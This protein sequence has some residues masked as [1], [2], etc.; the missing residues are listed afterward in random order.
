MHLV[1]KKDDINDVFRFRKLFG[2]DEFS[3]KVKEDSVYLAKDKDGLFI[4][5]SL[6]DPNILFT[7]KDQKAR[8]TLHSI[9]K[10]NK[11]FTKSNE[12]EDVFKD[13]YLD[14]FEQLPIETFKR[15]RFIGRPKGIGFSIS[16]DEIKLLKELGIKINV[17]TAKKSKATFIKAKDYNKIHKQLTG[18]YNELS[19]KEQGIKVDTEKTL[20][21]QEKTWANDY[22][23]DEKSIFVNKKGLR[24]FTELTGTFEESEQLQRYFVLANIAKS[25][26][27]LSREQ[28]TTNVSRDVINLSDDKN[29]NSVMIPREQDVNKYVSYLKQRG[30]IQKVD[31]ATG[32]VIKNDD[33]G[34]FVL[35]K[36]GKNTLEDSRYMKQNKVTTKELANIHTLSPERRKAVQTSLSNLNDRYGDKMEQLENFFTKNKL[37]NV[38]D[39]TQIRSTYNDF[40][41]TFDKPWRKQMDKDHV[42]LVTN[43]LV[44]EIGRRKTANVGRWTR[45]GL[46]M[47]R[48]A[49]EA[50][51]NLVKIRQ[52]AKDGKKQRIQ[53]YEYRGKGQYRKRVPVYKTFNLSVE[54][55]DKKIKLADKNIEKGVISYR[56]GRQSDLSLK[57]RADPSHVNYLQTTVLDDMGS[58][59]KLGKELQSV[60]NEIEEVEKIIVAADKAAG[61]YDNASLDKGKGFI[62]FSENGKPIATPNDIKDQMAHTMGKI[63]SDEMVVDEQLFDIVKRVTVGE[64]L[65]I[66][67]EIIRKPSNFDKYMT[68]RTK[69]GNITEATTKYENRL[70]N[71]YKELTTLNP[72]I[73]EADKQEKLLDMLSATKGRTDRKIREN[74]L[75]QKELVKQGIDPNDKPPFTYLFNVKNKV[76]QIDEALK[77][78]GYSK[79]GKMTFVE[80]GNKAKVRE[81]LVD[82]EKFTEMGTKEIQFSSWTQMIKSK[83]DIFRYK[84][85]DDKGAAIDFDQLVK[86]VNNEDI[87]ARRHGNTL[88][89]NMEDN[90]RL[91][92]Q[93]RIDLDATR[94]FI[95]N[96]EVGSTNPFVVSDGLDKFG[97]K[98]RG[99]GIRDDAGEAEEFAGIMD[100]TKNIKKPEALALNYLEILKSKEELKTISDIVDHRTVT[101][102]DAKAV[103]DENI[104]AT[105]NLLDGIQK[106]YGDISIRAIDDDSILASRQAFSKTQKEINALN[107]ERDV[108]EKATGINTIKS[109]LET[110]QKELDGLTKQK[111][112]FINSGRPQSDIDRTTVLLKQKTRDVGKLENDL[113][114]AKNKDMGGGRTYQDVL[115]DITRKDEKR[116]YHL[117]QLSYSESSAG[118][119]DEF[120]YLHTLKQAFVD[121]PEVDKVMK[122][123]EIIQTNTKERSKA[124]LAFKNA[125]DD[126]EAEY[127]VTSSGLSKFLGSYLTFVEKT[128][129]MK[130]IAPQK[131]KSMISDDS[132][133]AGVDVDIVLK[134]LDG[135]SPYIP[136]ASQAKYNKVMAALDADYSNNYH[137]KR[138]NELKDKLVVDKIKGGKET[139]TDKYGVT[140]T[141]TPAYQ[142]WKVDRAFRDH[143]KSTK[144]DR[145]MIGN[146]DNLITELETKFNKYEPTGSQTNEY[147]VKKQ[148]EIRGQ[149]QFLKNQKTKYEQTVTEVEQAS[150]RYGEADHLL[151][152]ELKIINNDLQMSAQMKKFAKSE[153]N[154]FETARET[155][156]SQL[157][158]HLV[159]RSNL[160]MKRMDIRRNIEGK[161]KKIADTNSRIDALSEMDEKGLKGMF[162]TMTTHRITINPKSAKNPEKLATDISEILSASQRTGLK[163]KTDTLTAAMKGHT[164]QRLDD[165]EFSASI[166]KFVEDFEIER[167]AKINRRENPD[168]I[169]S[170]DL[171]EAQLKA[172]AKEGKG[173]VTQLKAGEQ[174]TQPSGI[175]A[176]TILRS[177]DLTLRQRL[178][179]LGLPIRR[180]VAKTKDKD[181]KLGPRGTERSSFEEIVTKM[182]DGKVSFDDIKKFDV[183]DQEARALQNVINDAFRDSTVHSKTTGMSKI[184]KLVRLASGKSKVAEVTKNK[185]YEQ[186]ATAMKLNKGDYNV[187]TV[188][189]FIS[190]TGEFTSLDKSFLTKYVNNHK[191]IKTL[192]NKLKD[193]KAEYKLPNWATSFFAENNNK[194]ELT[195]QLKSIDIDINNI[196]DEN[197]D[198]AKTIAQSPNS[199]Q[200]EAKLLKNK[201]ILAEKNKIKYNI[202]QTIERFDKVNTPKI[203]K[204]IVDLQKIEKQIERA[205]VDNKFSILDYSD[206]RA[207]SK[208]KVL[209]TNIK[210][211]IFGKKPK[212]IVDYKKA[213]KSLERYDATVIK[214]K[215]ITIQR[216]TVNDQLLSMS[217]DIANDPTK[218]SGLYKVKVNALKNKR[219]KLDEQL[220]KTQI[221]KEN[222]WNEMYVETVD[223]VRNKFKFPTNWERTLPPEIGTPGS[224]GIEASTGLTRDAQEVQRKG[225]TGDSIEESY[226]LPLT[227]PREKISSFVN[228]VLS[229]QKPVKKIKFTDPDTKPDA[230][231]EYMTSTPTQQALEEPT[232]KVSAKLAR[233][234]AEQ[235][236]Q[237]GEFGKFVDASKQA[238]KILNEK[239]LHD[240][241]YK[242]KKRPPTDYLLSGAGTAPAIPAAAQGVAAIPEVYAE[243]QIQPPFETVKSPFNNPFTQ[244]PQ[245][246]TPQIDFAKGIIDSI[247]LPSL[248]GPRLQPESIKPIESVGIRSIPLS[249]TKL[250]T[251]VIPITKPVT[252]VVPR[253]IPRLEITPKVIPRIKADVISKPVTKSLYVTPFRVPQRPRHD[254]PLLRPRLPII[255]PPPFWLGSAKKK[256]KQKK[257]KKKKKAKILWQA[258]DWWGGYYD[259]QEYKVVKGNATPKSFRTGNFGFDTE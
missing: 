124:G 66:E 219:V 239:T 82:R 243:T 255:A 76:D 71:L 123:R 142:R 130:K 204:Q 38:D 27:K 246:Q 162:G 47:Y 53:V 87:V 147:G 39:Y 7:L 154:K 127:Q 95:K 146:L 94:E 10:R 52:L 68:V 183:N 101:A 254:T 241:K 229:P 36:K 184:E 174:Y 209:S 15:G 195:R 2:R 137:W 138:V 200:T 33:P 113:A 29:I 224:G 171:I 122:S 145:V 197:L 14:S 240:A 194:S 51:D 151:N 1:G 201:E 16:A 64:G 245:I 214:E 212:K 70:N 119:I 230:F 42:E 221:D 35:T 61:V 43:V 104:T 17:Q 112:D 88:L 259:P 208:G 136:E 69:D 60:D 238:R 21:E 180:A 234:L 231:A 57:I 105:G 25:P 44:D 65:S 206:T 86:S 173:T 73:H 242:K 77:E 235:E 28:L 79:Q 172:K 9:L 110:A 30:F 62:F 92:R 216:N 178:G 93:G 160:L 205:E 149:F 140:R 106:Q 24:N 150:E 63:K 72:H 11:K 177:P 225:F 133:I 156:E 22:I 167:T 199:P 120:S 12:T 244:G 159:D 207:T 129:Y 84:P 81:L 222:H 247:S 49:V 237:V 114:L 37:T 187:Q 169:H 182:N 181:V 236:K 163:Y 118:A 228:D 211:T 126:A 198:L 125:W 3:N 13:K 158:K 56:S 46:E 164:V 91:D 58:V 19:L 141:T 193:K 215:N 18:K 233:E 109:N 186:F 80:E 50:K 117:Q 108:I 165:F 203:K 55:I 168:V 192:K 135:K 90:Y 179:G 196:K 100:K 191:N 188:E 217:E 155:V 132:T 190:S 102:K 232:T 176:L 131:I 213:V 107:N 83:N 157:D 143:E 175:S 32:N 115:F 258:P 218:Y 111:N 6:D 34:N 67:G 99:F 54:Q 202:N 253:L 153:T 8:R 250:D 96:E 134:K 248:P 144:N 148:A 103:A 89:G 161:T 166:K 98:V 251:R 26:A 78:L 40:V 20:L 116:Q 75:I 226:R 257:P 41:S 4:A 74:E 189:Q 5:E 223:A 210:Q 152:K 23:A 128:P 85:V 249:G 170:N 97:N 227:Q 59:N 185:K 48:G 139:F 45:R 252:K 220:R 256:R 121:S 31:P